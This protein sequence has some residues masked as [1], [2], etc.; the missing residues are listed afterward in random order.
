MGGHGVKVHLG[1]GQSGGQ[2]VGG[3]SM[4]G[5]WGQSAFRGGSECGGHGVKVHLGGVRVGGTC[6][7][8]R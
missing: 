7:L 5:P 8:Q 1:G 4:G 6:P 3:V 2:Q